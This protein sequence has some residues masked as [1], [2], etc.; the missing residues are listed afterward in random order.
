MTKKIYIIVVVILYVS[1]SIVRFPIYESSNRTINVEIRGTVKSPKVLEL[2]LGTK[3]NDILS[4]IDLMDNADLSTF[5]L[6]SV[7][8]DNQIINI[9]EKKE[10]KL[11][12][13]NTASKDELMELA[14]I[15]EVVAERIIEYRNTN[16]FN[17]LEEIM[18]VKGIGEATY[19]KIREYICL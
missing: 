1:I 18:N 8:Y 16:S 12:S 7:L 15:G 3:F 11:I 2:P 9:P 6:N 5:S 19:E 13:I 4:E 14:G 10:N 17:S